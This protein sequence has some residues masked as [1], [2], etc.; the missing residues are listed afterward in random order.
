VGLYQSLTPSSVGSCNE[1]NLNAAIKAEFPTDTLMTL[2][3]NQNLKYRILKERY[4]YNIFTTDD[5]RFLFNSMFYLWTFLSKKLSVSSC[6]CMSFILYLVEEVTTRAHRK[7][8]KKNGIAINFTKIRK[9]SK[10]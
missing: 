8:F 2:I 5:F 3:L 10:T 9:K 4:Q 7:F 1:G 6:A